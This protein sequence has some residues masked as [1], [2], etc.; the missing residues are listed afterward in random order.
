MKFQKKFALMIIGMLLASGCSSSPKDQPELGAVSGTV[1][2]DGE[3]LV[4][5]EVIFGPE[6]GRSSTAFTDD[7][8]HYTLNYLHD[9][10]GAKLGPHKVSISTYLEDESD[11]DA[12]ANFVETIP[13]KYNTKTALTREVK[14]GDNVFDF[15]LKSEE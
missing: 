6:S 8:G 3:P 2:M 12:E 1:T 4:G 9:T 10:P 14:P 15:P 7:E 5:V 11:P 13:A